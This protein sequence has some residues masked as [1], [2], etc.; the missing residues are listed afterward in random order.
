M[1]ALIQ[2]PIRAYQWLIS[3]WLGPRCRFHPSCSHYAL[4]ALE[5]HGSVRGSWLTLKRLARCH[6]WHPGGFDPVP[7]NDSCCRNPHAHDC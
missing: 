3:P 1:R 5:R 2:L 4:E 6:P 7:L